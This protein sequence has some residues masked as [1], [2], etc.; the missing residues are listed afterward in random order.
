MHI[1]NNIRFGHIRV[2][3]NQAKES[4]SYPYTF[5]KKECNDN[6]KAGV[7]MVKISE[8]YYSLKRYEI[9]DSY[10]FDAQWTDFFLRVSHQQL[11]LA[12]NKKA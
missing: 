6:S 3:N 9:S 7:L 4:K 12:V 8:G 2:Q 5:S 11:A 10:Y 1:S